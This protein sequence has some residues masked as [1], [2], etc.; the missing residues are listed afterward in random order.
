MR[1]LIAAK[2]G[3]N[4]SDIV[5]FLRSQ[6]RFHG[7]AFK[8]L[9]VVEPASF[10]DLNLSLAGETRFKHLL[11][12]RIETAQQ[13]VDMLSETL[14]QLCR[15]GTTCDTEVVVGHSSEVIG[16]VAQTWHADFV[17]ICVGEAPVGQSAN[18][19][20]AQIVAKA[21]CPV[22]VIKTLKAACA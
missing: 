12:E 14:V 22:A 17:F 20:T 6:E 1:I 7:C 11:I 9:Q 21:P 18:I 19:A 2:N 4:F 8:V 13:Q 16:T 3:E 15:P 10:Y 5:D